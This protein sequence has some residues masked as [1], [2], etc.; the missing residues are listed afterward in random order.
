[1]KNI[2]VI[3]ASSSSKSINRILAFHA[4]K[5]LDINCQIT[6]LL[7]S[8]YEMPIY[9]EDLQSTTGIPKLALDFKVSNIDG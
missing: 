6:E 8:D 9:S 5:S 1:M 2:V 7:L 3:G 4:A